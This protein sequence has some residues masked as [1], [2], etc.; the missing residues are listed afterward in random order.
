[1]APRIRASSA[2]RAAI[3]MGQSPPTQLVNARPGKISTEF[4]VNVSRGRGNSKRET[5]H[6][7]SRLDR[8]GAER[9]AGR[10]RGARPPPPGTD[11]GLPGTAA[12]EP[13]ERR[14]RRPGGLP[15]RVPIPRELPGRSPLRDLAPRD[16]P[17][18]GADAAPRRTAP[19]DPGGRTSGDA[20][21][22]ATRGP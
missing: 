19:A 7:R 16:R 18:F 22:G 3:I 10:V 20:E 15:G 17:E 1:G 11:P 9:L 8:G 21:R 4:H 12:P 13:G 6:G 2:T 5:A 14:R